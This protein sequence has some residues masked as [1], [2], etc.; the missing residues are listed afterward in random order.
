M[1]FFVD[2]TYCEIVHCTMYN[3]GNH[4]L[5]VYVFEHMNYHM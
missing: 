4:I 2:K 3:K 5:L 1:S